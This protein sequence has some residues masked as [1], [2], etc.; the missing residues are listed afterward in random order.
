KVLLHP[1]KTGRLFQQNHVGVYRSDNHGDSWA[2]IDGGLPYDFGFGLALNHADPDTCFVTPL[3]P[4]GGTYR[5]T[6]GK[7]RVY[8]YR[9]AAAPAGGAP[10][11]ELGNGLPSEDA[12]LSVLRE[13]MSHDLLDPAGVYLGTGTGQVYH[14]SDA[15]ASWRAIATTLPPIL[16]V[17]AAVV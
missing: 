4:Q 13:G 3:E 8:R 15:G 17:S 9:G 14:S 12:Y 7:L 10:W 2:R 11:E 16:S 1:G 5:A 6:A